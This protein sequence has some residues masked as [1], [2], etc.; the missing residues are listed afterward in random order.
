MFK[1]SAKFWVLDALRRH[2]RRNAQVAAPMAAANDNS[3]LVTRRPARRPLICRWSA[4]DGGA[5]LACRWESEADMPGPKPALT[6]A[7]A[8]ACQKRVVEL[9][10]SKAA[11]TR[12]LTSGRRPAAIARNRRTQEI[13]LCCAPV[14]QWGDLASASV[15]RLPI[16]KGFQ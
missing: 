3:R 15:R 10:Y 16:A 13:P 7:R 8:K 1:T 12:R 6:A 4:V 5:R 9:S 2:A 14:T 11:S